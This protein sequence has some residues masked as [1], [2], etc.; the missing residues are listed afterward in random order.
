[1][2]HGLVLRAA[3]A[4]TSSTARAAAPPSANEQFKAHVAKRRGRATAPYKRRADAA[5]QPRG[6]WKRRNAYA[7]QR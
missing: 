3:R 6:R 7:G 4:T 1:M 5:P 2:R